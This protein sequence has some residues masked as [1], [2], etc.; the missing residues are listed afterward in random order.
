MQKFTARR[1]GICQDVGTVRL[2]EMRLLKN[3]KNLVFAAIQ[4]GKVQRLQSIPCKGK[5]CLLRGSERFGGGISQ[6]LDFGSV[7]V[8]PKA[9]AAVKNRCETDPFQRYRIT[10]SAKIAEMAILIT[11]QVIQNHHLLQ[12]FSDIRNAQLFTARK[13]ML[14]GAY[15]V[16]AGI[17]RKDI[18]G[19]DK[20]LPVG[21]HIRADGIGLVAFKQQAIL[22]IRDPQLAAEQ[23]SDNLVERLLLRHAAAAL[24]QHTLAVQNLPFLFWPTVRGIARGN[25]VDAVLLRNLPKQDVADIL[26]KIVVIEIDLAPFERLFGGVEPV[27]IGQA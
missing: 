4:C 10:Y 27:L 13:K 19:T 2:T 18:I 16:R 25:Q 12:L 9:G 11:N 1:Q 14:V 8:K 26:G 15:A 24:Y 23:R 20:I 5:L 21:C 7:L 17:S 6:R 3:C 22:N